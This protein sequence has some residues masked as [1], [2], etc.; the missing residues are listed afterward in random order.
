MKILVAMDDSKFSQAALQAVVSQI[1]PADVEVRVLHVVA[2]LTV[3]AS[4][5]MAAA[6]APELQD[7]IKTGHEL[8]DRAAETLRSSAAFHGR[9]HG[10]DRWP[11][12]HSLPQCLVRRCPADHRH[13]FR[14]GEFIKG[15]LLL[16]LSPDTESRVCIVGL[17]YEQHPNLY[18]SFMLLLGAYLTYAGSA[19]CAP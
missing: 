2:P 8:V 13:T 1:R 7:Q 12:D 16:A 15:M 18:A 5:Q 17:H 9:D 3:S 6:Y 4:P 11:G 10:N 14:L 19:L